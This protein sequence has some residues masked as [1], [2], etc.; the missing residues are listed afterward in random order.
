MNENVVL[1]LN[2]DGTESYEIMEENEVQASTYAA[3]DPAEDTTEVLPGTTEVETVPPG[4]VTLDT[5]HTDLQMILFLILFIYCS[6]L[7]KSGF[8]AFRKWHKG[9]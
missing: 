6:G 7:I 2:E 3:E 1:V 9:D 4:T 5:I 8:R